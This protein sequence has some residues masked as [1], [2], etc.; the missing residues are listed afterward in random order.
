MTGLL[1]NNKNDKLLLLL[2]VMKKTPRFSTFSLKPSVPD[3]N[4]CYYIYVET[5]ETGT[6]STV[7]TA[8][9]YEKG[10]YMIVSGGDFN[11]VCFGEPSQTELNRIATSRINLG[12]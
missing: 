5:N 1:I 8:V 9:P 10:K 3:K 12:I 4:H 2:K 11:D 6:T 7:Y